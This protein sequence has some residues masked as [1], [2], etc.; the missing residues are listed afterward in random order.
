M[1]LDW[2]Q[3]SG[4]TGITFGLAVGKSAH[5]LGPGQLSP[6]FSV[7]GLLWG[8]L[9]ER[10][11]CSQVSGPEKEGMRVGASRA[12]RHRYALA[13]PLCRYA[14]LAIPLYPRS[15]PFPLNPT[16]SSWSGPLSLFPSGLEG[17]PVTHCQLACLFACYDPFAISLLAYFCPGLLHAGED[18]DPPFFVP[19][20]LPP[21]PTWCFPFPLV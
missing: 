21:P 5:S 13:M 2:E 8:T 14:H 1:S 19:Y 15:S 18:V 20:P 6:F 4:G 17:C 10:F 7:V 9:L 3:H 16:N 12:Y 11:W